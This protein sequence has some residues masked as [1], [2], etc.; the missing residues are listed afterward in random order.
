MSFVIVLCVI[1]GLVFGGFAYLLFR[2]RVWIPLTVGIIVFSGCLTWFLSPVCVAIPDEDLANF[3]PPI[4][5]RTDTGMVGQRYFQKRDG[6][7]FHCK[8]R[9][10]RQLFF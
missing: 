2:R 5:T 1:L 8:V 4:D 3:K 10:A 6:G 9:I 7:W